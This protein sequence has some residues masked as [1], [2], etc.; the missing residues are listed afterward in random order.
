[1]AINRERI[2]IAAMEAMDE[3]EYGE[4]AHLQAVGVIVAVAHDGQTTVNYR[5]NDEDGNGVGIPMG[6]QILGMV[7]KG[8]GE[9]IGRPNPG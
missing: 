9:Q 6:I 8:I 2:G 1:M 3:M 4:D 5:F 7:L